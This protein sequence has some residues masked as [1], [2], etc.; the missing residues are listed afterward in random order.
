M[1]R[2]QHCWRTR[3]VKRHE[4]YEAF[5]DMLPS[6][7]KTLEAISH[8]QLF[9][10][11]YSSTPWNGEAESRNKASSLSN[12]VL[13]FPS[14][15]T[16][17]TAMKCLSIVKPLSIRT[18][19]TTLM[20]TRRDTANFMISK[21]DLKLSREQVDTQLRQNTVFKGLPCYKAGGLSRT[22][23]AHIYTSVLC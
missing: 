17:V 20:C 12:A 15:I 21:C 19:N 13:R 5:F 3:W 16:Q 2:K 14:L 18:Q 22:R 7:V 1:Q 11:Q 4:A 6:I 8:E 10:N 23:Y 9:Q